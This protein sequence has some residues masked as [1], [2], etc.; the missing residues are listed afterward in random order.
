MR[1]W[2]YIGLIVTFLSCSE[3]HSSIPA[4]PGINLNM[5]V[6]GDKHFEDYIHS[7][8]VYAFKE[9]GSG[10]YSYYRQVADL[11]SAGIAGLTTVENGDDWLTDYKSLTTKFPVGIYKLYFIANTRIQVQGILQEGVTSPEDIYLPYPAE[12][13][14]DSYFLGDFTVKNLGDNFSYPVILDRAVSRLEMRLYEIPSAISTVELS[15]NNIATRIDLDENLSG[16]P[17]TISRTVTLTN[18]DIYKTDSV[19]FNTLTFPSLGKSSVMTLTFR[20]KSGEVK[21]RM[22]DISLVPNKYLKLSGTVS[23]EPGSLLS[24]DVSFVYFLALDWQDITVPDFV[25]KP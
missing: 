14:T 10:K 3:D 18:D 8:S 25:L 13:L 20:S 7:L 2:I 23:H 6:T 12:G 22:D 19:V 5:A 4:E 24:F 11:D 17:L 16:G 15:V 1:Y 9:N 21:T